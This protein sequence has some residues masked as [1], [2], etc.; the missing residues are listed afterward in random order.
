MN[1]ERRTLTHHGTRRTWME[2]TG[3]GDTLLLF[4]HGLRQSGNVARSFT[5][6]TFD[7]LAARGCTVLYPDGLGRR[8]NAFGGGAD[9]PDDVGFLTALVELHA[10]RRV[11]GCGFSNGG[12]MLVRMLVDAPGTLQGI[13]TFGTSLPAQVHPGAGA[14]VPTPVLSVHGTADPLVPYAGGAR[15][16]V[17][18]LDAQATAARLAALNGAAH[19]VS[20][21]LGT[22]VRRDAWSGGAAPVE[23]WTIEGMGHVVP[24][25]VA[26]DERLGP[27]TDLLV[28]AE[29]VAGFFGL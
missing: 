27:G 4:L 29:L 2:V 25:P 15:A 23:L 9:G 22:G 16:G 18:W 5:A 12:Q 20:D 21:Q 24:A 13:A 26:L 3:G 10:P 28:G 1:A 17:E 7:A 11:I 14:W 8:F 6:G 19:R